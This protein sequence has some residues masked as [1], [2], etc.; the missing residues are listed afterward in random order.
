MPAGCWQSA[1]ISLIH[2][3]LQQLSRGCTLQGTICIQRLL[4]LLVDLPVEG[5]SDGADVGLDT[6][7]QVNL[8]AKLLNHEGLSHGFGICCMLLDPP[9]QEINIPSLHLPKISARYA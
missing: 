2:T 5:A 7:F 4:Q 9:L 3:F 6:R 8:L 1:N